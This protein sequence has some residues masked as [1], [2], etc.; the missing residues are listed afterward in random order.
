MP[1]SRRYRIGAT[2]DSD[3]Y[4]P[5]ISTLRPIPDPDKDG[6]FDQFTHSGNV[7]NLGRSNA[8]RR[9]PR[10]LRPIATAYAVPTAEVPVQIE[11]PEAVERCTPSPAP[12][13][14]V[15]LYQEMSIPSSPSDPRS[16][17]RTS[18]ISQLPSRSSPNN[19]SERSSSRT[20]NRRSSRR[21]HRGP[22]PPARRRIEQ[23]QQQQQQQEKTKKTPRVSPSAC[24]RPH[25]AALQ[26]LGGHAG[27]MLRARQMYKLNKQ[28]GFNEAFV[29]FNDVHR[30]A[31]CC[32]DIADGLRLQ[33]TGDRRKRAG[34]RTTG[35]G[36][37][38]AE[39]WDV[40][41]E[42][43]EKVWCSGTRASE[44]GWVWKEDR[45]GKGEW[46][47]LWTVEGVEE[48]V[49]A[50]A[51]ERIRRGG[52]GAVR[53]EEDGEKRRRE[54]KT[55]GKGVAVMKSLFAFLGS[56]K[57][58]G[59]GQTTYM[60]NGTE[61]VTTPAPSSS[62]QRVTNKGDKD[63]IGTNAQKWDYA[64]K[65]LE[66]VEKI[67]EMEQAATERFGRLEE[68]MSCVRKEEEVVV[69]VGEQ[70]AIVPREKQTVLLSRN[71]STASTRRRRRVAVE[72]VVTPI[73]QDVQAK[74]SVKAQ[75][76]AHPSRVEHCSPAKGQVQTRSEY[77]LQPR[78]RPQ[79]QGKHQPRT[80]LNTHLHGRSQNQATIR[81]QLR[82]QTQFPV[83]QTDYQAM[84]EHH[85]E[86][87]R[88]NGSLTTPNQLPRTH[89]RPLIRTRSKAI[90]ELE[91]LNRIQRQ[92]SWSRHYK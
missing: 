9:H 79:L 36:G 7:N 62:A 33:P 1:S 71:N 12:D 83:Q 57:G 8:I 52:K 51:A 78:P 63:P 44:V 32:E 41:S 68:K 28:A 10:G 46:K 42:E 75:F 73:W 23:Q 84:R 45:R 60:V 61:Y 87:G 6:T 40:S 53:L 67:A 25:L 14:V 34:M 58:K 13:I 15:N 39:W 54:G 48:R 21:S 4:Y 70:C 11:T 49:L 85:N 56:S 64:L 35:G 22:S 19:A 55:S 74:D 66:F 3:A 50:L 18:S 89:C 26:S 80:R 91:D 31:L 92:N 77:E 37:T 24:P 27:H 43:L 69:V 29:D 16:G 76:K 65:L 72:K 59:S 81:P 38:K 2:R 82:I 47:N 88:N 5:E 20:S 30:I 17:S 86:Y 90:Y